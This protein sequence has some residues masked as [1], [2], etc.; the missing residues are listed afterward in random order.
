M[1]ELIYK[2]SSYSEPDVT[3]RACVY[4]ATGL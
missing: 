3:S 4:W 1:N 2:L